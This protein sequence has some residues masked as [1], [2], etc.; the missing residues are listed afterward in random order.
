MRARAFSPPHTHHTK[1]PPPHTHSVFF[2]STREELTATVEC[3]QAFEA[4]S[5]GGRLVILLATD[6]APLSADVAAELP[7]LQPPPYGPRA[8][9]II[10]NM[11]L[12]TTGPYDHWAYNLWHHVFKSG[13]YNDTVR[14]LV[15]DDPS[16]GGRVAGTK[17]GALGWDDLAAVQETV[18]TSDPDVVAE[19]LARQEMFP[20][21]WNR[22]ADTRLSEFTA[23]GIFTSSTDDPDWADIHGLLPRFFNSLKI[24]NYY[25]TSACALAPVYSLG[26]ALKCSNVV[27]CD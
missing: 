5:E 12:Y 7:P 6:G 22:T 10:G 13:K 20:K 17:K 1:H 16:H 24:T 26:L 14:L 9:P 18:Y 15:G 3:A 4:A 21:T 8:L 11:L 27:H 23:N 25:P 19:L 2:E